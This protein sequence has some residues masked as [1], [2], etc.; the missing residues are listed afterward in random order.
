MIACVQHGL[1]SDQSYTFIRTPFDDDVHMRSGDRDPAQFPEVAL[2]VVSGSL[3]TAVL[4]LTQNN[5][6]VSG[7]VGSH[8]L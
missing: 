6:V 5:Q 3:V 1:A 4:L 2:F 7:A 8:T